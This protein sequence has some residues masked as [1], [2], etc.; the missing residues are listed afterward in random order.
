LDAGQ[1][2][3]EF[4]DPSLSVCEAVI[5]ISSISLSQLYTE[6][7]AVQARKYLLRYPAFCLEN[8]HLGRFSAFRAGICRAMPPSGSSDMQPWLKD[9]GKERNINTRRCFHISDFRFCDSNA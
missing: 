4:K 3:L 6:Q 7:E 2:P 9:G 8:R 5:F 1:C